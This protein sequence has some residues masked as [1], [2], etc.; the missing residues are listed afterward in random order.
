MARY[1][2]DSPK[3]KEHSVV[4]TPRRP[5]G[6][7]AL[8]AVRAAL[9]EGQQGVLAAVDAAESHRGPGGWGLWQKVWQ[10]LHSLEHYDAN[11]A[12]RGAVWADQPEGEWLQLHNNAIRAALAPFD[13]IAPLLAERMAAESARADAEMAENR[14]KL[15]AKRAADDARSQRRKDAQ[16]RQPERIISGEVIYHSRSYGVMHAGR[17]HWCDD[18][19]HRE[20][21]R[22]VKLIIKPGQPARLVK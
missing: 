5:Y 1:D 4:Q 21:G 13:G 2:W 16:A 10:K 15:E 3:F 18:L 20:Q 7:E 8:A 11:A 19:T 14:R 12:L 17:F 6:A 9:L 22:V